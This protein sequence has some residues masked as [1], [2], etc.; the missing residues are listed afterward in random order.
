MT[1]TRVYHNLDHFYTIWFEFTRERDDYLE[2]GKC[3]CVNF[4]VYE[5][6]SIGDDGTLYYGEYGGDEKEFNPEYTYAQGN[7]KWDGCME[8]D[9]SNHF[10][11]WSPI[12]GEIF[13]DVYLQADDIMDSGNLQGVKELKKYYNMQ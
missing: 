12:F 2:E 3:Y 5:I 1:H 10:C 13:K 8:I 11:G 6:R 7:I 9:L 4:K